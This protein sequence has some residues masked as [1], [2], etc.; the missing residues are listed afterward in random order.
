L[1][2][3]PALTTER[4]CPQYGHCGCFGSWVVFIL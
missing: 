2:F 3:K 1:L 4:V